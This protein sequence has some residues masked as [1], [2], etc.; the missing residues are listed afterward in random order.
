MVKDNLWKRP[1][2]TFGSI[3]LEI[4]ESLFYAMDGIVMHNIDRY[5]A[6]D[7]IN[8]KYPNYSR[9]QSARTLENLSQRGYIRK[10]SDVEGN[11]SVEFTVKAKM[12]IVDTIAAELTNT[13]RYHFV[14][15]D[16]PEMYR[17]QRNKFRIALKRLGFKQI[18]QSLWVINKDAGE[19]VQE[20]AYDLKIEKYL[21]YVVSAK[22]DIDGILDEKFRN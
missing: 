19:L 1:K 21:V 20:I 6:Y 13:D 16:I 18:Q 4:L 14:S 8:K 5:A 15:F 17:V 7:A 11:V 12:K 3:T 2:R 22:S 10:I 9:T